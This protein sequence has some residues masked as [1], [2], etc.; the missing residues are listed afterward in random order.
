MGVAIG[1]VLTIVVIAV[2]AWPFVRPGRDPKLA[3]G[4]LSQAARS[5]RARE[6]VYTQI[7]QLETDRRANLVSE[8]EYRRHLRELRVAAAE[9]MRA[10]ER[11]PRAPLA[12]EELELEIREARQ[13]SRE[14]E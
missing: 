11:A 9:L 8:D 5:R 3:A 1:I 4:K 2:V 6:D 14:D 7:R 13:Q 12:E 10:Q